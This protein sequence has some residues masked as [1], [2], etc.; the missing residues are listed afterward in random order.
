MTKSPARNTESRG[1]V[2]FVLFVREVCAQMCMG[3]CTPFF[4]LF[5]RFVIYYELGKGRILAIFGYGKSEMKVK[6]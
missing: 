3:V 6:Q 1:R 4:L 5:T 2:S